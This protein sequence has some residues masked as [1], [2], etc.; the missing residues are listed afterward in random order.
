MKKICLFILTVVH[1]ACF[2]I[3]QGAELEVQELPKTNINGFLDAQFKTDY[4]TPRGLLVNHK[5]LTTQLTVGLGLDVYKNSD[6]EAIVN[7]VGVHGFIWNDLC[8]RLHNHH[9]GSWVECDWG[10]GAD[11]TLWKNWTL[12]AQF[13]QF[14]SP[15]HHFKREDNIEFLLAY[16]DKGWGLPIQFNP[17]AKWFWAVSGDSTVVTGKRGH[18]YDVELGLVPT[19]EYKALIVRVP[20]WITVGP[21]EFWNGGA[22]GLKHHGKNFGVFST[23]LQLELP[24]EAI[25]KQYGAWYVTAGLQYYHIINRSLLKAQEITLGLRSIHHAHRNV[26]VASCGLGFRF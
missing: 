10:A 26:W 5:G 23:G 11:V 16:N 13:L 4:M 20:T 1:G 8:N 22:L 25:P 9:V 3:S 14:L 17:Y 21:K 19:T 2:A 15:P 7:N 18:T 12:G 6:S 24:V